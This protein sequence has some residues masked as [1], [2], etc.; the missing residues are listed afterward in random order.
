MALLNITSKIII[1]FI[2]L[3]F[4]TKILGKTQI[5]QVTAFDFISAIVLGEILGNSI[6]DKNVVI[7]QLL[8]TLFL[9]AVLMYMVEVINQKFLK[10][11][12]FL[13]G[14]PSIV[15]SKGKINRAE[16]KKNKINLNTLQKL[17]RENNVFSV[18]E[19]EYAILET[20]GK[21]SILKK[22]QYSSPTRED[23]ELPEK[24]VSLPAIL[25]SDGQILWENLKKSGFDKNWLDAKLKE[26]HIYNTKKVF[27]AEWQEENGLYVEKNDK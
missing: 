15:I 17:L 8:Y 4:V 27:Y 22:S 10:I 3:F 26:K 18:R 2:L 23:M 12:T 9:W 21:L 16:L 6:Y 19:V 11:R 20:S 24:K 25:I 14:D 1:G 13:E 7:S 5:N